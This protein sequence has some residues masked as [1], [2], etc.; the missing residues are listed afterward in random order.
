LPCLTKQYNLETYRKN[1]LE[2]SEFFDSLYSFSKDMFRYKMMNDMP[3]SSKE[4]NEFMLSFDL[5]TSSAILKVNTKYF[6]PSDIKRIEE[7]L[8]LD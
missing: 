8:H 7:S 5:T 4:E 6:E 2:K 1:V 3:F